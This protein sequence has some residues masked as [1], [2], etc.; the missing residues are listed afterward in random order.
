LRT[1]D[2]AEPEKAI[3]YDELVANAVALQTVVDQTQALHTLISAGR[4]HRPRRSGCEQALC[5]H[6]GRRRNALIRE[7]GNGE[8]LVNIR[9]GLQYG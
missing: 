2:P 8:G 5:L 3:V 1:N 9:A 7:P 6:A 4:S